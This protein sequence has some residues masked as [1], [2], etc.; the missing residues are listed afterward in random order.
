M[1]GDVVGNVVEPA[2]HQVELVEERHGAC[3]RP[4][5]PPLGHEPG[6]AGVENASGRY[7]SAVW[8]IR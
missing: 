8:R 5:S 2:V 1:A 3:V 4:R 7:V 6:H